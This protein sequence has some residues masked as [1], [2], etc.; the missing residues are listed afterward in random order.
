M[1]NE[2]KEGNSGQ[3]RAYTTT[4][5]RAH[6]RTNSRKSLTDSHI[7]FLCNEIAAWR[8]ITLRTLVA[9]CM[10][11]FP[12]YPAGKREEARKHWWG[13]RVAAAFPR[14]MYGTPTKK[15]RW[16]KKIM[17]IRK[18][19]EDEPRKHVSVAT[20]TLRIMRLEQMVDLCMGPQ[21]ETRTEVYKGSDGHMTQRKVETI[22]G[23]NFSEAREILAQIAK[24]L[25]DDQ[26][27][28]P[29]VMPE[30]MTAAKVIQDVPEPQR[31]NF[32]VFVNQQK[33][34]MPGKSEKL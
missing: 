8:G 23:P 30:P 12:T 15:C 21:K 4:R 11:E 24:E 26:A 14:D 2:N 6:A 29:I 19:I 28:H 22:R 9:A 1:N 33:T 20:K 17:E 3:P 27:V 18:A 34:K 25:G 7:G 16:E 31:S 32:L 10:Q 13:M 5:T